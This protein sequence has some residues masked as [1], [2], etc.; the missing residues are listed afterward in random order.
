MAERAINSGTD[1]ILLSHVH[2]M[3]L[4]HERAAETGR[5]GRTKPP[6]LNALGLISLNLQIVHCT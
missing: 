4:E 2:M 1:I 5:C 6:C 3:L